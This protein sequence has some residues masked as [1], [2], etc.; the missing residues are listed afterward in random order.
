MNL[1][2]Y[3]LSYRRLTIH[4]RASPWTSA[5][6]VI[7]N[8][9]NH[10]SYSVINILGLAIGTACCILILM[11]MTD[12]LSFDN[13]HEKGDRIYKVLSFSTMGT[14]TR[15][16]A[17]IPP[18]MAPELVDSIPEVESSVRIYGPFDLRAQIENKDLELSELYWADSTFFKME[19]FP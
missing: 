8:F 16:Y 18:A 2:L 15:Q 5:L 7:R 19:G 4:P 14:T 12:E 1:H 17:T 13:Y 3:I 10:K 6:R 9:Y 11:Y